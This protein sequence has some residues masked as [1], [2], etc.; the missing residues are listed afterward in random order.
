[1]SAR[2]NVGWK[3]CVA[4]LLLTVSVVALE[5][6]PLGEARVWERFELRVAGVPEGGNPF[7]PDQLR[8][9]AVFE[10]PDGRTFSVP[11]FWYRQY[12]RRLEGEREVLSPSGPPEW[13]VRFLPQTNGTHR[14]TV[15]AH[16]QGQP[17]GAPA[18]LTFMAAPATD[19]GAR[20]GWVRRAANGR[21][22]ETSD[23]RP[24]PLIGHCV[25]WY[26]GRGTYDYD[27]WLAAMSASGENYTRLW[28][29]PWA[30]GIEAEA[31][32]GLNYRL[33]RAWQ[34]DRVFEEAGRRGV[35]LMLCFDYHGMFETRPDFWGG[36]DNWKINPYNA[37]NGGP[38]ATQ[39]EFFTRPEARARYQKRL[40]YL[41]ARY[42]WS[43]H[44][45]A[46]QFFNEIDNVYRYL[47]PA[48]VAAW[49]ADMAAWLKAHDPWGHLVTTSLTGGSDRADI[50]QLPQL[51]FAMYHSYAQARPAEALPGLVH[52]FLDRYGK[53]VMIGE[54]GTDWR[55]WR[56][57]QDPHLRGWRQGLWAGALSGSV[58]TAMS[59]WWE[60]IHAENLY[61]HFAALRDI[62][63]PA[64]WGEGDWQPLDFAPA[65]EP[66]TSLGEPRPGAAPF[67]VT[68]PLDPGWG[69]PVPGRLAVANPDAAGLSAGRLNAFV[70]GSAHPDLRRP[71]QLEA[72]LAGGARL[73]LHVNSVSGGAVL[74]VR[75]DG[76]EVF[77]RSLPN[78]DSQWQVNG[79]YNEDLVVD[80]PTGRR[81]IEVRNA[82]N[83]WVYL[84]WVRL[85]NVLPA[86]YAGGWQ[87]SLV[88]VGLRRDRHALLYVVNPRASWPAGATN[89]VLDAW[90][91]GPVKL[92]GL[93]AGRYRAV[94][95]EPASGRRV[96]ET[97]GTSDG[98]V[99][100]LPLPEFSED[101]A[102]RVEPVSEV[103]LRAPRFNAAGEFEFSIVGEAGQ[104]WCVE[105]SPDC[106]DWQRLASGASG[107]GEALFVDPTA[108]G[109][110]QRFYR[111]RGLR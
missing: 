89:A 51:D 104:G 23:G 97:T 44:L 95:F 22:F 67:H 87:P 70:H 8:V 103:A 99:L 29:A 83:D 81:L 47:N 57:E 62:L 30:F 92:R 6:T 105:T 74:T 94:W 61:P 58:G 4:G 28:M 90:T 15:T 78:K 108:A 53:P 63:L 110:G 9:D 77:R 37:A 84:D 32:T 19:A 17:A 68:L 20:R 42:G 36:N 73:V 69:T 45:L 76:Q 13:R 80:L 40:R 14:V 93:A 106:R 75:V 59:W 25:C 38:C 21:F 109:Q 82:G 100:S 27:T 96:A 5:L 12:T 26:H 86:A 55:G 102:G 7:D 54:F 11:G 101:L 39:N 16:H 43:P 64:G 10:A 46:W 60:S 49:H 72:W 66:P 71:F 31:D 107:T 34:L 48:D 79:E 65:G 56:R 85:E 41:V 18:V 33:D 111:A 50:W 3:A 52:R 88:A 98:V 1:M 24:L 2:S 35:Y 91:G